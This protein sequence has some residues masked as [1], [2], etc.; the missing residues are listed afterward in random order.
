MVFPILFILKLIVY[1]ILASS[2]APSIFENDDVKK[3]VL[4]QLFG[5]TDRIPIQDSTEKSNQS[6][7]GDLFGLSSSLGSPMSS[8]PHATSQLN[9]SQVLKSSNTIGKKETES[10]IKLRG[11]IHVLLCGDPAMS[12]SQ[13]LQ[14]CHKVAPR[15]IYTSGKGSSSVGLTAYVTRDPETRQVVLER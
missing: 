13:I 2:L 11:N 12:K 14:Y 9:P 3:S 8:F 6:K 5:G 4:L 1:Q 7:S 10:Q 15:G